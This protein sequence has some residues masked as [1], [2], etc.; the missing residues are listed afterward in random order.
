MGL[1]IPITPSTACLQRMAPSTA[2]AAL[3][4]WGSLTGGSSSRSSTCAS[5]ALR[6]CE[7]MERLLAALH[8]ALAGVFFQHF[9]FEV[10]EE[11]FLVYD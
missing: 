9:H 2:S 8:T 11:C 4:P 5:P 7:D 10:L 1:T 3:G 6:G